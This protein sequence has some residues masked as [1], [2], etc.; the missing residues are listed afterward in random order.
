MI[1]SLQKSPTKEENESTGEW[2]SKFGG[3]G[4]L[5]AQR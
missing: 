5:H 1:C 3:G 4:V 2:E